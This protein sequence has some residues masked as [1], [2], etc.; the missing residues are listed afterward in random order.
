MLQKK[1]H[2]RQA[3]LIYSQ[4]GSVILNLQN[5]Q[6][7]KSAQTIQS[8]GWHYASKSKQFKPQRARLTR[9]LSS[10]QRHAPEEAALPTRCLEL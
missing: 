1:L 2:R 8:K 3:T 6:C 7:F 4:A 10:R 9:P 5:R